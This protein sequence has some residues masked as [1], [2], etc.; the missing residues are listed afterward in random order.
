MQQ[1]RNDSRPASLMRCPEAAPV[2]AMEKFVEENVVAE[3]RIAR[4]FGVGL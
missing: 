1:F 2:V 3:V 4:E